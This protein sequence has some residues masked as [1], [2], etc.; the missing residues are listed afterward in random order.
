MQ[1]V[2]KERPIDKEKEAIIL[3]NKH[4]LLARLL[5]QRNIPVEEVDLFLESDYNTISHPH[6]LKGIE[7]GVDLFIQ[8]ALKKGKVAV[9][10][11]YDC[12]GIISSVM[13]KELCNVFKLDCK[14]FLPSRIEHGYGLTE[15]T[16]NAFKEMAFEFKPDLLFILDC[17]SSN[18]KEIQEL[19]EAGLDNII[20]IDL[21]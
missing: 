12:D 7:E 21:I 6:D 19:K 13:I 8:I 1:K 20:I 3:K 17:G 11:D 16:V 9:I 2:W 15:N 14:V 10:G 5:S 18:E 4:K